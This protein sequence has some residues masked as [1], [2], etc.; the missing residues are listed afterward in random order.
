[1]KIVIAIDSFKGSISSIQAGN[2]AAEGVRHVLPK[3]EIII[4][5]LA[6][7]GEGTMDTLVREM[8]GVKRTITVTSPQYRKILADYGVLHNGNSAIIETAVAVGLSLTEGNLSP[9]D[10]T[11]RGIGEIIRHAI[12]HGTRNFI[13]G[14]GGSGTNDCGIGMLAALGYRFLDERGMPVEA[15]LRHMH[16]II[17]V[18][19]EKVLP[20]LCEC[21][22]CIAC[23]VNNP[24]CGKKGASYVYGPQKGIIGSECEIADEAFSHFADVTQKWCGQACRDAASAGAAGGLGFAFLS[25]LGATSCAGS[26][27]VLK[28]TDLAEEMKNADLVI[29]GEGR[30]DAQTACGKAP[31]AVAR[32]AE[33]FHVPVIGLAGAVSDDVGLCHHMGMTA[34]FPILRQPISQERAMMPQIAQRNIAKTVEEIIRLFARGKSVN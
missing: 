2:A 5:P 23:D 1:M 14:L 18:D 31:A 9:W 21:T 13:I 26:D 32:L 33:R 12:R 16:K 17:A 10:T 25:Y 27:M 30:I 11:S 8:E 6:D 24:L 29:T 19:D 4:K 3:A 22:F 28:V 20:E 15:T 7:G 34:I